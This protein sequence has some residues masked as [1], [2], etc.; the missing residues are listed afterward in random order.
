MNSHGLDHLV[1]RLRAV[2]ADLPDR[3]TGD[4]TRFTMADLALSAFAVFFTQCPS[5]LSFQQAME[6]KRGCNN[7]RSLFQIARIPCD[8]HIRQML[9]PIAPGQL[10]SLF[11]DLLQAFDQTGLLQ[12]MR[13]V[14]NT[15]LIALDATW[16]FSSQSKNIHGPNCSCLRHAD[17]TTT[18][19]HS[20]ITPVIVSPGHPQVVPLCPEFI[21]PQDG[22]GQ[23][24][25][26]DQRRQTLAGRARDAFTPPATTRCWATIFT[27]SNPSAGRCCCTDF[28]FSSP[29]SPRRTRT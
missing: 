23:T 1:E 6:Q 19:F 15:R 27:R 4:N 9:D 11:E 17:G 2:A 21:T 3:R 29:A 14:G 12:Q 28:I 7:A 25:L 10:F 13:A 8:N 22:Q 26:R 18:H 16:Y 20:A 24:G 5:F